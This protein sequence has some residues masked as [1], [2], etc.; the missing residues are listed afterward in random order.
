MIISCPNTGAIQMF[1]MEGC[2]TENVIL[3]LLRLENRFGIKIKSCTAD[4]GKS[5]SGGNLR[6]DLRNSEGKR[7]R[8]RDMWDYK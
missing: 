7:L 4:A 8:K 5:L 6:P 3:V 2:A 1:A